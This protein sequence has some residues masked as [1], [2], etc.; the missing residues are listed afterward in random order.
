[1]Q[2]KLKN[3]VK[4]N[5]GIQFVGKQGPNKLSPCSSSVQS[6]ARLTFIWQKESLTINVV[7]GDYL[8]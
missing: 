3:Q 6:A 7:Y 2:Y 8:V 1:M 4:E 5:I